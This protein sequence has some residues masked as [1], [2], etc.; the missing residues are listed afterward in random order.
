M[1]LRASRTLLTVVGLAAALAAC[2]G[3]G[4]D[5]AR[6]DAAVVE[7]APEPATQPVAPEPEGAAPAQEAASPDTDGLPDAP[8]PYDQLQGEKAA[9]APTPQKSD[10]NLFY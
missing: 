8:I 9:N 1:I 6:G 10:E 5:E 7:F 4:D 2:S 3:G